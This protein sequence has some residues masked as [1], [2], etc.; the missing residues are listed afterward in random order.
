MRLNDLVA[1]AGL[2]QRA[3]CLLAAPFRQATVVEKMLLLA[4][5]AA[6]VPDLVDE[7]ITG[8]ADWGD[9]VDWV[10]G[11]STDSV[12]TPVLGRRIAF[13]PI[14]PDDVGELYRAAFDPEQ[15]HRWRYRGRTVSPEGFAAE[16]HAGVLCQFIA[17]S[18]QDG[19]PLGIVSAYNADLGNGHCYAAIQRTDHS[20][21]IRMGMIEACTMMFGYLFN[22]FAIRHI[23]LEMVEHNRFMG[24]S[25]VRLG[26]GSR[27]ATY[28]VHQFG[29]NGYEDLHVFVVTRSQWRQLPEH[30]TGPIATVVE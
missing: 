30:V 24:D 17:V 27:V 14:H 3:D 28:P 5:L 25:L 29:P 19:N 2:A 20:A 7:A 12:R 22:H 15:S 26:L 10:S 23:Y 1:L 6:V 8:D 4:T 16:L 21:G 13:R 9:I 11:A 18:S